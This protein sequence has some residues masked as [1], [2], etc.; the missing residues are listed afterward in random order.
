MRDDSFWLD[1]M[2]E[3]LVAIGESYVGCLW[4]TNASR[5][6]DDVVARLLTIP[7]EGRQEMYRS[8]SARFVALAAR[9]FKY[10][11]SSMGLVVGAVSEQFDLCPEF[12]RAYMDRYLHQGF[13]V[14]TPGTTTIDVAQANK[15]A[16]LDHQLAIQSGHTILDISIGSW[17]GVGC[18]LA[19]KHSNV[20]IVSIL[21]SI[22]EL[23]RAKKFAHELKVVNRI[24][25]V[26]AE[27][28]QKLLTLLSG[29]CASRFNRITLCGVL[30]TTPESQQS[31]LLRTLKRIQKPNGLTLLEFSACTATH[32]ATH[33]W[34]NK[35][36]HGA[37][38]CYAITL[39]M[40]RQLARA[41]GFTLRH[42]LGYSDNYERTFLEW[43]RRF[44]AQYATVEAVDHATI[45]NSP[46]P[47]LPESFKRTWEFYLLH[48]AACYRSGA[49]QVFQI[50]MN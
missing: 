44:Q 38:P 2:S 15:L 5:T 39:P 12:R 14:W 31:R 3:G 34:T 25:F 48:S 21:S 19:Q 26:L 24:E 36:V 29:F 8:W 20:V 28:P 1:W 30:E 37:Y 17:G 41:T 46:M 43:N 7:M 6:L 49:L 50:R 16:E 33:A 32:M 4:A 45:K 11:P 27:T 42:T 9:M 40:L 35:Y 18:H 22:Q 13:G 47:S 10:S 23:A